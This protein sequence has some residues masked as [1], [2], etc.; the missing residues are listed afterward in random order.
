MSPTASSAATAVAAW[1]RASAE[2]R[3]EHDFAPIGRQYPGTASRVTHAGVERLRTS[4]RLERGHHVAA[5]T[6]GVAMV[7]GCPASEEPLA[8]L[9]C[10]LFGALRI[11]ERFRNA[12]LQRQHDRSV[13]PRTGLQHPVLAPLDVGERTV[14]RADRIGDPTELLEHERSLHLQ[15]RPLVGRDPFAEGCGE[16]ERFVGPTTSGNHR[17][18][19]TGDPI[20]VSVIAVCDCEFESVAKMPLGIHQLVQ[21]PFGQPERPERD[22]PGLGR[23]VRRRQH[24]L[25][26]CP[27][28]T[29]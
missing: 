8:L 23:D 25:R 10:E 16:P 26:R 12:P 13:H 24:R 19:R 14:V 18:E 29:G 15:I 28:L 3:R 7:V 21:F 5:E 2:T 20:G 4:E 9:G 6:G 27:S 22:P 11:G 17:D 1:W